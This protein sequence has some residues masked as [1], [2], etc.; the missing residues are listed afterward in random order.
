MSL[1]GNLSYGTYRLVGAVMGPVPPRIGYVVA[2]GAGRLLYRFDKRLAHT[3]THNLGHVLGPDADDDKVQEYVRRACLNIAK[4]HYELFR[5]NR[6]TDDEIRA[7]TQIEG[8]EHVDRALAAGRGV[9]LVS[10]HLG[11]VDV[12]GQLPLMYGIPLTSV[13]WRTKP[14]RLFRYAKGLRESHGLRLIPSDGSMLELIRALRRGE[15]IILAMDRT[16][17]TSVRDVEFFGSPAPL[18]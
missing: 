2:R 3:L 8:R 10:A 18:G 9:I 15:A 12:V 1:R 5:V 11:N 4:G 16:V 13:V 7:L 14:E 6:L 17:G